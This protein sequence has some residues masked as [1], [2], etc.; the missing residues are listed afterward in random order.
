MPSNVK[1]T[2]PANTRHA[3]AGFLLALCANTLFWFPGLNLVLLVMAIV[4]SAAG[5]HN[6]KKEW[7]PTAV[8]AICGL[9]VS[10]GAI[11]LNILWIVGT[12][13]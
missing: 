2:T 9:T 6:A 1:V 8:F 13:Q 5:L 3:V 10:L 11:V 7:R 4:F 12:P